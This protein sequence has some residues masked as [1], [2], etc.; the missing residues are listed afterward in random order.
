MSDQCFAGPD[1]QTD[2]SGRLREQFEG[3][4]SEQPASIVTYLLLQRPVN[5]PAWPG[6]V[7]RIETPDDA[8]SIED[9][10]ELIRRVV[11]TRLANVETVFTEVAA[12]AETIGE[13]IVKTGLGKKVV[14]RAMVALEADGRIVR[15]K[16]FKNVAHRFSVRQGAI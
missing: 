6:Y 11:T 12:G 13:V 16:S 3:P 1:C 5:L 4:A 2:R 15:Q 7:H 14:Q 9:M 8:E 10:S